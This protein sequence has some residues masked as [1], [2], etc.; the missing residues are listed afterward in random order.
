M[1]GRKECAVVSNNCEVVTRENG[2]AVIVCGSGSGNVTVE[3]A[4]GYVPEGTYTDS[5]S[6]NVF[7][8]TRDTITGTVGESGIAVIYD[9][10]D[11]SRM[12]SCVLYGYE[13]YGYM[14][15]DDHDLHGWERIA[16]NAPNMTETH[17]VL[18]YT[19]K[20]SKKQTIE[21]DFKDGDF[22]DLEESGV[23]SK[24][25]ENTP[26]TITLTGVDEKGR[27]VSRFFS[28]SFRK[29]FYSGVCK[30][31]LLFDNSSV[32]WDEVYVYA[33]MKKGDEIKENAPYPGKKTTYAG[34]GTYMYSFYEDFNDYSDPNNDDYPIYMVFNDGKDNKISTYNGKEIHFTINEFFK[35]SVENLWMFKGPAQTEHVHTLKTIPARDA[36]QDEDGN[37][38]Y[39]VCEECGKLFADQDGLAEIENSQVIIPTKKTLTMLTRILTLTRIPM[40]QSRF[41]LRLIITTEYTIRGTAFQI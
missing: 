30:F 38:E 11:C 15:S 9:S 37:I 5:V 12:Y 40:K 22:I 1:L 32:N 28:Y 4:G 7:T 24:A 17:Y 13:E 2:G 35:M 31:G 3:N 25:L 8:V 18:E 29:E 19:D 10:D 23:N 41:P 14:K 20:E 6:G 36:T 33:Y 39:F 26:L 34:S 21:D 16:L 27:S